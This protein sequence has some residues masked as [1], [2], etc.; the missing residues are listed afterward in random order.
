[1]SEHVVKFPE[2][3]VRLTE[4]NGNSFCIMGAVTQAMRLADVS[5]A[6]I[7]AYRAEAIAGNYDNLLQVTMRYVNVN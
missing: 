1:M 6:D 5:K 3:V 2:I 7:D 4:V